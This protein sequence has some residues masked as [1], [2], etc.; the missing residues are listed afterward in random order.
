M[1]RPRLFLEFSAN[2]VHMTEKKVPP[3]ISSCYFH[4]MT[5]NKARPATNSCFFLSRT[6]L[7]ITRRQLFLE[8]TRIVYLIDLFVQVLL[9]TRL[10]RHF[11]RSVRPVHSLFRSNLQIITRFFCSELASKPVTSN[12][13]R[14]FNQVVFLSALRTTRPSC[15]VMA[16]TKTAGRRFFFLSVSS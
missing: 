13:S 16:V 4:D 10:N 14:F 3:A 15:G 2:L 1:Y 6:W 9:L 5:E 12:A 11:L 8:L 7:K